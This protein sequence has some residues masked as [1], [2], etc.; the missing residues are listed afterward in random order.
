MEWVCAGPV[1]RA[2]GCRRLAS[3]GLRGSGGGGASVAALGGGEQ[4]VED[5]SP[6]VSV[7]PPAAPAP[8]AGTMRPMPCPFCQLL[9]GEAPARWVAQEE[10]AVAFLPL[11]ADA[12]A[13]GHTL[14]AP[15]EHVRG[16]QEAFPSGLS[17]AILLVQRVARAMKTAFGAE[18]VCVLNASG[19]GSGQT[20]NHLHFHVVP[21]WGDDEYYSWPEQ[22]LTRVLPT[23]TEVA[24]LLQRS[25]LQRPGAP[26]FDVPQT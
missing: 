4:L 12:L 17:A 10:D 19:P 24:T 15:R 25:L 7:L 14:V 20:V 21:H 6:G 3:C 26:R 1:S 22:R 2:A 5:R 16:V 13:P 23:E 11:P 8:P 18:G 9:S